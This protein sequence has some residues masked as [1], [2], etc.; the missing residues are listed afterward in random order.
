MGALFTITIALR[1]PASFRPNGD[2]GSI[3]ARCGGNRASAG[4]NYKAPRVQTLVSYG[5]PEQASIKGRPFQSLGMHCH[6]GTPLRAGK[7]V[8]KPS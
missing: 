4:D 5:D 3:T 2:L 8:P 6:S 1:H 7:A